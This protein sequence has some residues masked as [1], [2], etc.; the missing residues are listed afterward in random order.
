[1][2]VVDGR[3]RG[4]VREHL[5]ESERHVARLHEAR[6]ESH[7]SDPIIFIMACLFIEKNS[8]S[9][10]KER[11]WS[12]EKLEKASLYKRAM[13]SVLNTLPQ[14][15]FE[16]WKKGEQKPHLVLGRDAALR[17]VALEQA[18]ESVHP[19]DDGDDAPDGGERGVGGRGGDGRRLKG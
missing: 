19:V 7:D 2:R 13:H 6:L 1:M 11:L 9:Y 16:S 12:S 3:L 17:L 18:H 5:Q 8:K 14:Y 15:G 10:R 4:D